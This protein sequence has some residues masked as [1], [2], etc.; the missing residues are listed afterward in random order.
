[1]RGEKVRLYGLLVVRK[2]SPPHARGKE[3]PNETKHF[4]L[5]IT[6]ACAGK[7]KLKARET[8]KE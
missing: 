4:L 1:M 3:R 8:V 2:G 7:R 6:P 5:R